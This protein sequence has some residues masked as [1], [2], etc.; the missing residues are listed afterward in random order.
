LEWTDAN[1]NAK[2]YQKFKLQGTILQLNLKGN[3]IK[4]WDCFKDIFKENP[5]YKE[6]NIRSCL[7]NKRKNTYWSIWKFE[8]IKPKNKKQKIMKILMTKYIPILV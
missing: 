8:K 4:K 6:S 3:L 7:F 2:A 5:N 1:G